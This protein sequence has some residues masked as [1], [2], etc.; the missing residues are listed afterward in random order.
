MKP[1]ETAYHLIDAGNLPSIRNHGLM[2][3]RRLMQVYE[4]NNGAA[5]RSHR[6]ASRRLSPGVLIRDQRPMPPRA[7]ISCLRSGLTPEDW[8]ELL[9]S[10]VFFWLDPERL[11]RQRLACGT[12]P[13]VAFVVNASRLL[14]KY[15]TLA[16]VTPINT[17]N[18]LRKAAP[19]NLTTFVP[20]QRWLVDGWSY[21]QVPGVRHRT[22]SHRPVEL[23]IDEAVPDIMDYV[24]TVVALRAGE[25]LAK[26]RKG[27]LQS[28]VL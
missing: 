1:I 3:A 22:K 12:A 27:R 24:V 13:Q 25:T 10:K 16:T 20:Y 26:G 7:L 9:N 5:S 14:M 8:F 21:E 4:A 2:S 28:S 15:S 11:N 17:G 6:P 18:A 23:T 19:R